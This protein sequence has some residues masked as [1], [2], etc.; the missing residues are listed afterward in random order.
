MMIILAAGILVSF[1]LA[2]FLLGA[3]STCRQ[4]DRIEISIKNLDE[5]LQQTF[6]LSGKARK[7]E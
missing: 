4:F 7:S 3:W 1:N 5:T 6:W 2:L